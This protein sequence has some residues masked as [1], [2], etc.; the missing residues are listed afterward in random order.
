MTDKPQI[1]GHLSIRKGYYGAAMAAKQLGAGAFQ[2]FSK[3]PRSL[4]IKAFDARDTSNCKQYCEKHHLVSVSHTPYPTNLAAWQESG[5]EKSDLVVN[6]LRND[7]EIAEACGS[8]GIV[9]HF[10]QSK[11]GNP[12]QIYKNIIQCINEVLSGWQGSAKLLIENQAG[13][14]GDMGMTMEELVQIR[15]L[16]QSPDRIGY[17]LDTCHAFAAGM[18][19]GDN[20]EQFISKADR[21]GFWDGLTVIHLNDSKYPLY[22]R[23][24]RHARVGTGFI[25]ESG[26][27]SLFQIEQITSIPLIL[28]SETGSDGTHREDIERVRQWIEAN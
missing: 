26:F 12:L 4:S 9:V 21:L 3:N 5:G 19:K 28:E 14:H 11:D 18:W 13:D 27:Q 17:C 22:S 15:S 10:G 24:D 6:S 16:C 1:G 8:L 23:K 7:L 20:D 2:Y 25:G